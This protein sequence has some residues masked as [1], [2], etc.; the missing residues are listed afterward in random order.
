M[1]RESKS[2][3]KEGV[4]DNVRDNRVQDN[5]I[6]SDVDHDVNF[7]ACARWTITTSASHLDSAPPE[8]TEWGAR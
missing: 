4:R 7:S 3:G 8:T 5:I 6:S 1:E 2:G